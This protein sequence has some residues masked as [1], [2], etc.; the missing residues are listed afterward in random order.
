MANCVDCSCK[1]LNLDEHICENLHDMND[2]KVLG[3]SKV[4]ADAELCD[5]PKL[6]PKAL[7]SIWCIIKNIIAVICWILSRLDALEKKVNEII[8]FLRK[9]CQALKCVIEYLKKESENKMKEAFGK[10]GFTITGQGTSPGAGTY[11]KV[12]TKPDGSFDIQWNMVYAGTQVGVGHVKGKVNHAYSVNNDGSIKANIIS[13]TV[14]NIQYSGNGGRYSEA[15]FKIMDN[16]GNTIHN[17]RYNPGSTYN[18]AINK[19]VAINKSTNLAPKGGSFNQQVLKTYDDW[20]FADT[21]ANVI[22]G[23]V[24]NND[25]INQFDC[26]IDCIE[27]KKIGE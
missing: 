18:V 23:Y 6:F 12:T 13:V 9:L 5:Y 17:Q 11:S 21:Q 25:T 27:I 1:K 4:L 15:G 3:S 16:A 20:D 19:T 22:A 24:N 7:Y 10:V 8:D 14:N 2:S 26:D